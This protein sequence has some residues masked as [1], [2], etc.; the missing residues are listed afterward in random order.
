[1]GAWHVSRMAVAT[2]LAVMLASL[3]A[4]PVTAAPKD[5]AKTEAKKPE[6]K[7]PEAKPDPRVWVLAKAE[8]TYVLR[9]GTP[10]A[11][12]P[13]FAVA[14]QPGAQL[15]Q[16]TVEA[17]SGKVKAGDGVALTLVAGKRRLEL[18]AS[19]FRAAT[20]GR[21]VVEAAVSLDGRVLDLFTEGET[22]IV[23]MPGAS[24]SYPLAGAKAKLAD[25]RR[26]CLTG[27]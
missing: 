9:Y 6:T 3:T 16:F 21:V 7:K 26:V 18:A 19:A 14:C 27:R 20:E 13:V 8:D 12:D 15:I 17:A 5:K 1:M 11:P 22:L 24:E 4:M 2:A 10:R 23:R 25:F